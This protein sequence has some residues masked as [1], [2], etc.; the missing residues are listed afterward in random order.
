MDAQPAPEGLLERGLRLWND[1]LDGMDADPDELVLLEEACRLVDEIDQ[2]VAAL[3]ES[4]PVVKGSRNQPAANPL[5]RE[6]R[7]HRLTLT[8]VLRQL[9]A[10]RPGDEEPGERLTP[11]ERGRRAAVARHHGPRA[12]QPMRQVWPP[13]ESAS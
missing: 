4:G 13:S 9:G 3:G 11:S 7:G 2:M 8:R 1:T 12:V 6:I 10:A 5:I